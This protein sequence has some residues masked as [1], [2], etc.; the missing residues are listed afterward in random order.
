MTSFMKSG[1]RKREL[2]DTC[3]RFVLFLKLFTVCSSTEK[4]EIIKL[5]SEETGRN[6]DSSAI[7]FHEKLDKNETKSTA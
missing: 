4:Y 3:D 5:P 1:R 2:I 7:S 6:I